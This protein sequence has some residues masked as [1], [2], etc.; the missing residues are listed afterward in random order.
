VKSD[1]MMCSERELGLGEDSGGIV[2]LEGDVQPGT[3]I[4][5]V[6]TPPDTV[7]EIEVTPNRP[8]M[9]SHVG[10]AREV[11]AIYGSNV[12]LPYDAGSISEAGKAKK[13]SVSIEDA[14]DCARYVAKL[15]RGVKVGPSPDWLVNSLEAVGLTSRNNIVDVTNFVLMELGQ[16]IHAFDFKKIHGREIIVRRARDGEKLLTLDG[17][18]A[19]LT[20]EM[21][22]IAD[23]R[24]PVA[25]AGVIGGEKSAVHDNTVDVLIESAN[26]HPTLVRK[27]R[28]ALGISTD[29]SYRFERGADREMCRI[30]AERAAQLMCE[31]GGA[32]A[33]EVVD[34]YPAPHDRRT[35]EIRRSATR[36]ILGTRVST[37]EITG[38]L[39]RL[40][41]QP[42]TNGE[43]V[44]VV[45]PSWRGDV[46]EEA[47]LIEEVAR[48][49]GYERIGEGWNFRATTYA[50]SSDTDRFVDTLS[51][52]LT[53]R[54]YTEVITSS[55]TDGRELEDFG[56]P[57]DDIR[58][59][60]VPV[61]NPLS[62]QH[63]FLKTSLI[64]GMLD[65]VRRNLD[66]DVRRIKIYQVGKVFLAPEA[67]NQLPDERQL[68]ALMM[69]RPG[70]ADFWS[71][72]K[73]EMDLFDIK[74][75]IEEL[76][77]LLK[78]D[79]TGGLYYDFDSETGAFTWRRKND[80]VIEGGIVTDGVARRYDFEQPVWYATFDLKMLYRIGTTRPKLRPLPEYP[81][82]RRDLSLLVK[83]GVEFRDVEKHLVKSA[84]RLLESHQVFDVYSG[85]NVA[86]NHSAYG[87]RLSFRSAERTLTDGEVDQVIDKILGKL[88]NELGVELRT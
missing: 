66:H 14:N 86:K 35:V 4:N 81:V 30:A 50:V 34:M 39:N 2:V 19:E 60:L 56:W 25:L 17:T 46:V 18:E 36:R 8:D 33:V 6:L 37:E 55:F 57:D 9:L 32:E 29:A 16:P 67:T 51:N 7:L 70:G 12:M 63:R 87:I 27:C 78:V 48:L 22:V 74:G 21:L 65:V 88:K 10:I 44:S 52:H 77:R 73:L 75:E 64:P 61:R 38:I 84:G 45:V 40:Q 13:V 3:P 47:D 23:E 28:N 59:T 76:L 26:F 54:G 80:L 43:D 62:S 71:N 83:D 1:G 82:S 20:S 69:T 41:F 5:E 85:K 15:L 24:D 42:K 53:A 58:R 72:T 49:Y 11:A 79:L 31:L 68:L